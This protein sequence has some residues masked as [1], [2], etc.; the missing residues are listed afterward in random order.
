MREAKTKEGRT[1]SNARVDDGVGPYQ[2]KTTVVERLHL[3]LAGQADRL[4]YE[5]R[6]GVV[7]GYL[8]EFRDDGGRHGARKCTEPGTKQSTGDG[9]VRDF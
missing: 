7:E 5:K 3:R 9:L 6:L 2:A 4:V 1:H 8:E